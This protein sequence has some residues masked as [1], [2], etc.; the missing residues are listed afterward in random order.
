[1]KNVV[2]RNKLL[3]RAQSN[4]ATVTALLALLSWVPALEI[5]AQSLEA[6]PQPAGLKPAVDFWIKVYTEV[7]TQS[8]YLHDSENLSVIYERLRLNRR[9]IEATRTEIREDLR[10]LATGARDDLSGSQREILELWPADVSNRTLSEAA[11]NIR[12]QLGQSD[13]F[14][15][16]LRRSGAFR[17]HIKNVI[18]EKGLPPELGVLPHVESSFN[19]SA[20]SSAAATGMWQFTRST[21]QRF[22]GIT[23]PTSMP[24]CVVHL[25]LRRRRI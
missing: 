11:N 13:R 19:P 8:G 24:L 14:L 16:G 18:L 5:Q 4:F 9:S 15:G 21:G 2:E 20:Y 17:Q 10:Y 22:R 23:L 6:F 3:S 12:W 7:D 1:M 25:C